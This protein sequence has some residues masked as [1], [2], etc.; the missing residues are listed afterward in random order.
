MSAIDHLDLV[1][2]SLERSLA[3]YRGLLQPLGYVR[4]SEIGPANAASGSC[5]S[6]AIGG[7]GCGEPAR[8]AVRR[9]CRSVRPLRDRLA[10]PRVQRVVARRTSTSCASWLRRQGE[11]RSRAARGVRVHAR[12]LR[13]VLLRAPTASSSSSCTARRRATSSRRSGERLEAQDRAART[14]RR[15]GVT[16]TPM[17]GEHGHDHGHGHD[18]GHGHG[19]GHDPTKG[20]GTGT[21][22]TKGTGKRPWARP[23][24]PR[25][26]SRAWAR[27]QA[28]PR[29]CVDQALA[30]RVA[31]GRVRAGR[32]RRDRGGASSSSSSRR[33]ASRCSPT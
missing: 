6:V 22:P 12:L 31:G 28:R 8:S 23:R 13:G 2:T 24:R 30:R 9:A 7:D 20:T 11:R 15:L 29:G 32:A 33:A 14:A 18:Q 26:R 10:P 3:F 4:V 1:V 5:T 21:T 27:A 16:D 17:P 25:A 19:H